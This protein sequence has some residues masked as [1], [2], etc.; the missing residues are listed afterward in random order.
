MLHGH[1]ETIG[2]PLQR[3]FEAMAPLPP[4]PFKA[5]DQATAG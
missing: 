5:C 3:D 4:A 1:S 2:E